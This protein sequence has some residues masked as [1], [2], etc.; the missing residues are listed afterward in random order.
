[1][2]ERT[3]PSASG[4]T[5][6]PEGSQCKAGCST[7]KLRTTLLLGNTHGRSCLTARLLCRCDHMG[8]EVIYVSG[9][10][11]TPG[12]MNGKSANLNNCLKQ[13]YPDGVP[14]P[15]TE[16][17]CIFDADQVANVDFFCKMLPKFDAGEHLRPVW[18]PC[19]SGLGRALA[20][21]ALGA[22]SPPQPL[23]ASAGSLLRTGGSALEAAV[24]SFPWLS[25]SELPMLR[26]ACS[27]QR[28]LPSVSVK[29]GW[30]VVSCARCR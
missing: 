26:D 22:A 11:R 15:G 8:P 20:A 6:R 23:H 24:A 13:I 4:E 19:M 16:L 27:S 14:I 29:P 5:L 18:L 2:T 30:S 28:P 1:M 3:A 21:L 25:A 10:K 9:R 12:E 17:V 7:W